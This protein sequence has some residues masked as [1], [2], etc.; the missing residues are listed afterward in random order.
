MEVKQLV[1]K[2]K[3][4]VLVSKQIRKDIPRYVPLHRFI[5]FSKRLDKLDSIETN[6]NESFE[7]DM[8]LI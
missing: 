8:H 7:K 3:T 1:A 4:N 2:D 5:P 6:E